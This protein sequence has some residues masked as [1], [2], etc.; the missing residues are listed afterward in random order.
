MVMHFLL[1][2]NLL[3]PCLP[4]F[5]VLTVFVCLSYKLE[6][7][8]PDLCM[9]ETTF[10]CP[11][12]ISSSIHMAGGPP[13]YGNMEDMVSCRQIDEHYCGHFFL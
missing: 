13:Q 3:F 1:F 10:L 7:M 5:C 11:I 12:G 2:S 6:Q 9:C 4:F 8:S